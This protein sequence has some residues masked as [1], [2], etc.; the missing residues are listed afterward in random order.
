MDSQVER[1]GASG[2][3][4]RRVCLALQGGGAH[5]AYTWGVLDR[6]LEDERLEVEAISGTSAGAMNAAVFADGYGRGGRGEAKRALEAFWHNVSEATRF[7]PLQPSLLDRMRGGW[8]LDHSPAFFGLDLLTR[9]LSPYQLNPA[10]INP[11]RDVLEKSV[12]FKR[13]AGCRTVGLFV[14]AT[15]VR[16]GKV[17]VFQSGEITPDVLLA[18]ACLP[19]M[20][21]AV[22]VDGEP[23]WDGGY[24]GNPSLF[25]LI[26]NA[27]S[28]DVVIVQVNPLS[29]DQVP[30]T[31]AA[32][33][34]RLNEISFNSSLMREMRAVAFVTD[35]ID[36]GKL[37]SSQYKRLNVHWIESEARMK[38]LGVSSKLNAEWPFLV[39]L[40]EI[41]RQA[42]NDWLA[43]HFD[44][45]GERSTVDIRAKFL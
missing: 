18:S 40:K 4:A 26:Y 3:N 21:Q 36:C 31:A 45:I 38:G 41:G 28:R 39:Y 15:N 7:S 12:D 37:D 14:S 30:T 8:N 5:G 44:A 25:P 16:T 33:M 10:N 2:G 27:Q 9:L 24:M 1:A 19:F 13:L 17:R 42:A 34:N 35:L 20:F 29:C 23:Y 6:L 43:Q 32:I 11:L 22:V